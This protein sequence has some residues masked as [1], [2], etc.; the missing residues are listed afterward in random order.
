VSAAEL[1]ARLAPSYEEHFAVPH[2]R[3]YDD[4]AWELTGAVL[5]GA[6]GHVVDV[7]C[8]VG[9]WAR[10][11]LARGYQVTGIEPVPEMASRAE[12][13]PGLTVLRSGVQDAELPAGSAD[14]VVAMGSIQYAPDPAGAIAR[15]AGWLRPGGVLAVLTDSRIALAVELLRAGKDAE[16]AER[17]STGRGRWRLDEVSAGMH[18]FDR[19][20]LTEAVTAAG[21]E[22]TATRG[23]LIGASVWGREGLTARLT[24]DY[25]DALAAERS[26]SQQE[27]LADLGKQL[28]AIARSPL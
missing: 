27:D 4:L 21:L 18:L 8:G 26:L 23:L 16:A 5:P 7:G 17:L 2:R 10:R 19:A 13:V 3:A 14:V 20:S 25:D 28:L 15:M 24:A 9:R 12:R 11:Y 22:V 1:F 6:P